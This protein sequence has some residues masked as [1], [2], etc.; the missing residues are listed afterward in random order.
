MGNGCTL[1]RQVIAISFDI[2]QGQAKSSL[3]AR[4]RN[5]IHLNQIGIRGLAALPGQSL[6]LRI[7]AHHL[8][9]VLA[10]RVRD[11]LELI[12]IGTEVLVEF[13]DG[14]VCLVRGLG[15]PPRLTVLRFCSYLL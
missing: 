4:V 10:N 6:G 15:S 7:D 8:P 13:D 9:H 5:S 3:G 11:L 12:E 14:K 1:L 2:L